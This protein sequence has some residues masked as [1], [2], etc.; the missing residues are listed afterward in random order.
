MRQIMYR[1][2]DCHIGSVM[3]PKCRTLVP[4]CLFMWDQEELSTEKL[5]GSG[6]FPRRAICAFTLAVQ[7][8]G[9]LDEG[10][11]APVPGILSC[12]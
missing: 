8:G 3:A 12:A 6:V 11:Q 10:E 9:M 1:K 7:Q 5:K 2:M 4:K